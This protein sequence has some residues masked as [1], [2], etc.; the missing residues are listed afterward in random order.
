MLF[1]QVE[2]ELLSVEYMIDPVTSSRRS[3]NSLFIGGGLYQSMG[4]KGFATIAI[5]YNVLETQYSPYSNPLIRVGFG[6][7]F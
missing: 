2:Y 6:V 1:A 7:G 4:G 3:I 5:L